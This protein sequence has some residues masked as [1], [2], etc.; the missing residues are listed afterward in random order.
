MLLEMGNREGKIFCRFIYVFSLQEGQSLA[1]L[2]KSL[3]DLVLTN[4]ASPLRPA[5]TTHLKLFQVDMG[6]P[7]HRD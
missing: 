1:E 6:T 7:D 4:A 5:T 2:A 3:A